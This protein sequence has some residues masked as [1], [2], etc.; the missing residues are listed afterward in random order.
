M[1]E[2]DM[3]FAS[4]SMLDYAMIKVT[5]RRAVS[6]PIF[7]KTFIS[8]KFIQVISPILFNEAFQ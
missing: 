5:S 3:S 2:N 4:E 1:P 8:Y 7:S 6:L